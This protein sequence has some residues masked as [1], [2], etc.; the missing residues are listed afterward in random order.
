MLIEADTK[1]CT[2]LRT[3]VRETQLQNVTIINDRIEN[4]DLTK[5]SDINSVKKVDYSNPVKVKEAFD[6][7]MLK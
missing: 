7:A 3:V 4:T 5:N 1:K 6:A 2:F